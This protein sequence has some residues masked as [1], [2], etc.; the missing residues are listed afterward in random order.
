MKENNPYIYLDTILV[1]GDTSRVNP[2]LSIATCKIAKRV[3]LLLAK[4][5]AL[6]RILEAPG[7]TQV[8]IARKF[9]VFTSQ[10][11]LLQKN[12]DGIVGQYDE[13]VNT[14]CK[15][16]RRNKDDDVGRCCVVYQKLSQGACLPEPLSTGAFSSSRG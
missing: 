16:Q 11:S 9:G 6:L 7:P 13:G 2:I 10:V 8:G 4:N 5:V 14:S 12:K 15:Q 1:E 3:D